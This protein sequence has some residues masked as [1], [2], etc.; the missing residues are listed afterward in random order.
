MAKIITIP[1][2]PIYAP[3]SCLGIVHVIQQGDTLY[4]LGKRFH[5]SVAQIMFSNPY[6]DVYNLQIGDELCI[7][8]SNCPRENEIGEQEEI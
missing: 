3:G 5:V 1:I 7:P 4:E 8:I 6:V 2:G